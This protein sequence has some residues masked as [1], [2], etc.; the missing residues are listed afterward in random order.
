MLFI[1]NNFFSKKNKIVKKNNIFSRRLRRRFFSLI[2]KIFRKLIFWLSKKKKKTWIIFIHTC[3]HR[4]WLIKR[5]D[6]L[7]CKLLDKKKNLSLS[8]IF[9][10]KNQFKISNINFRPH[11]G[12]KRRLNLLLQQQL[13]INKTKPL[14]LFYLF[15]TQDPQSFFRVFLKKSLQ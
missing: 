5:F 14:M 6:R 8:T 3:H 2:S 9:L 10:I 1:L 11:N 15:S 13:P 7:F 4:Q 12:L